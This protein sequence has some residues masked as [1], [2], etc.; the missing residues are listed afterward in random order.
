MRQKI[1]YHIM[2]VL[3]F[4]ALLGVTLF[5]LLRWS[6]LPAQIPVHYD[7]AGQPSGYGGRGELISLM[8]VSWLMLAVLT[9]LSFFPQTWNLPG[10]GRRAVRIA[11]FRTVSIGAVG[12]SPRALQA[13][14]DMLA[15]LR[16]EIALLFSWLLLCSSQAKPVGAWFLPVMLAAVLANVLVGLVRSRKK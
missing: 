12:Q 6:S 8:V 1:W 14:A 9:V 2:T 13:A 11:S 10:T 7:G 15:V 5:V 3:S 4:L 16:L